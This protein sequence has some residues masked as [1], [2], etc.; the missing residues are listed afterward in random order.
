MEEHI[1]WTTRLVNQLLGPLVAK[2]LN[3]LHLDPESRLL[4]IPQ[5]VATGIVSSVLLT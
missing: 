4:L 1:S 2:I 5:H 3:L